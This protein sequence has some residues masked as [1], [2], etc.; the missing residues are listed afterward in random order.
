MKTLSAVAAL[1]AL[2]AFPV[3][4]EQLNPM[5]FEVESTRQDDTHVIHRIKDGPCFTHPDELRAH[6]A[7]NDLEQRLGVMTPYGT[8]IPLVNADY[9]YGEGWLVISR[10][11]LCLF[12]IAVGL[13]Y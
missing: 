13:T 2:F 7:E 4:A 8:L 12:E 9:T 10:E 11:K 5:D 1:A 6:V 3:M